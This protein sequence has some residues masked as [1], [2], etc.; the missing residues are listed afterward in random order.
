MQSSFTSTLT[1]PIYFFY[2]VLTLRGVL[3]NLSRLELWVAL[4]M[5]TF[6]FMGLSFLSFIEH[7]SFSQGLLSYFLVQSGL[8]MLLLFS[9][10]NFLSGVDTYLYLVYLASIGKLGVLPLGLWVY[11]VFIQLTGSPLFNAMTF[12]K[13]P[14]FIL[15]FG[16]TSAINTIAVL[17]LLSLFVGGIMALS[18]SDLT[19]LLVFSS[20]RNNTWLWFSLWGKNLNVFLAFYL[21]Y[22]L[23]LYLA[24]LSRPGS[25]RSLGLLSLSGLPPSPLFLAKLAVA[26]SIL[27]GCSAPYRSVL[28]ISLLVSTFPVRSS[29]VRYISIGLVTR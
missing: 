18:A 5:A 20:I 10:L 23:S 12:Q 11:P 17:L 29:Y 21:T 25:L 3:L 6:V 7:G 8:S 9:L 26:G 16:V 22:S 19:R 2:I 28:V 4:E 1:P 13:L 27:S 24:F 15:L 14:L